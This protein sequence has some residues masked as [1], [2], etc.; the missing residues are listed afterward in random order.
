MP[1]LL[2]PPE[3]A[4]HIMRALKKE[5]LQLPLADGNSDQT[6]APVTRLGY[7]QIHP[8]KKPHRPVS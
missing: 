2:E 7:R 3:A 6:V 8:A 5:G 4:R 1:R